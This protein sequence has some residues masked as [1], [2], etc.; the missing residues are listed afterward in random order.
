M[1]NVSRSYVC[2][3]F[4]SFWKIFL[5]PGYVLQAESK[6]IILKPVYDRKPKKVCRWCTIIWKAFY[7]IQAPKPGK[8]AKQGTVFQH[9]LMYDVWW[10]NE[11]WFNGIASLGWFWN[12]CPLMSR[13]S[14]LWH[15][16]QRSTDL[17][18]LSTMTPM[19]RSNSV[20]TFWWEC[21]G[22][23]CFILKLSIGISILSITCFTYPKSLTK[24]DVPG[25]WAISIP[26]ALNTPRNTV[27]SPPEQGD[28]FEKREFHIIQLVVQPLSFEMYKS[29][30]E[31]SCEFLFTWVETIC[32]RS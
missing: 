30:L 21:F 18:Q 1:P 24:A 29:S 26:W 9:R 31:Q 4:L 2:I 19:S 20:W 17:A 11:A 6:Y 15:S 13:N 12:I 5:E 7:A 16:P 23:L 22:G 10:A 32:H 27:L 3:Y 28:L 25:R 8:V 14:H